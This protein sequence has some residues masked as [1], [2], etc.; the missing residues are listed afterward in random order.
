VSPGA[1]RSDVLRSFAV[2]R[3]QAG[4]RTTQFQFINAIYFFF[5]SMT[6]DVMN[7]LARPSP[8]R[9]KKMSPLADTIHSGL[10]D[11]LVDIEIE[12]QFQ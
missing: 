8:A 11:Y 5:Q 1:S 6:P 4:Y 10:L 12:N 9:D 3:V 2:L 7:K